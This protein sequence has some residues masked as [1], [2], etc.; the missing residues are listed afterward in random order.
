MNEKIIQELIEEFNAILSSKGFETWKI[1]KLKVVEEKEIKVNRV[2]NCRW[3][4]IPPN[5]GNWEEVC[6]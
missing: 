5:S 4:E 6:D 3:E 1:K 2:K